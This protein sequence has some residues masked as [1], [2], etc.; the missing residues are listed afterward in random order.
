MIGMDSDH[1]Q[2]VAES[3]SG[4]RAVDEQTFASLSILSERLGRLKKVSSRFDSVSF[5]PAVKEFKRQ[6]KAVA[7]G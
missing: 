5:S 6:A 3:L 4:Q 2:I 1:C 7:V